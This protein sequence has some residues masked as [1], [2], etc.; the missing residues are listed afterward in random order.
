MTNHGDRVD[1]PPEHRVRAQPGHT[2]ARW[3]CSTIAAATTSIPESNP[4]PAKAT[5]PEA[6]LAD[7]QPCVAQDIN[8]AL[9]RL[10][11][12]L[13]LKFATSLATLT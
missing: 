1:P 7:N 8:S 5:D 3:R 12:R 13:N 11:R 4:N 2:S 9:K 10:A 6:R